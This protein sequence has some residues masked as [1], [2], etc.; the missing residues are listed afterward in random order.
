[1]VSVVATATSGGGSGNATA[2]NIAIVGAK[3]SGSHISISCTP[4]NVPALVLNDCTSSQYNVTIN[5]TA[6]FADRFNNILGVGTIAT[7]RSEAGAATATAQSDPKTGLARVGVSVQGF[8]LPVDVSPLPH[9]FSMQYDSGCGV[10]T[11]NP[12][13]GLVTIVVLAARNGSRTSNGRTACGT[14]VS[15]SSIRAR[16]SSI[17][18][19]TAS[20]T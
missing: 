13:D 1:M 7:F 17:R 4:R 15:S 8:S 6:A 19:T 3:A 18:T 16:P 2:S 5:C 12:R 14:R 20:G 9:E 10:K 11:H